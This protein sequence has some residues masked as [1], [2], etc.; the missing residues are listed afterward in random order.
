MRCLMGR[1][2][3]FW[4]ATLGSDYDVV[5]SMSKARKMGWTGYVDTYNALDEVMDG[6]EKAKNAA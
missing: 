3:V 5:I 6:L 1:L 2:G 4:G